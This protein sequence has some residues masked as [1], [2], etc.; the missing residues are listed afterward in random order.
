[1]AVKSYP[2]MSQENLSDHF[3]VPEFSC[4][5]TSCTE[6]IIDSYLIVKLEALR[7]LLQVPIRIN[8]GYRCANYQA[9]LRLRGY[10]TAIGLSQHQLGRAADIMA[11]EGDISGGVLETLSRQA[12]FRA[13]GVGNVWVHVD[14][15][16]DKDRRWTYTR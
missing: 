7:L 4:P 6:T 14:L 1:V 16:D 3:K 13:V 9:E 8:S 11:S 2:K 15:R 5:C 10:E 12:G